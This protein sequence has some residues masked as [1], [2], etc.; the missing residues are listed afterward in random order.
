VALPIIFLLAPVAAALGAR[1]LLPPW[2]LG[3]TVLVT[4]L[5]AILSG[6]LALRT[7]R[8]VQP[9]ILLH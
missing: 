1:V 2:L 9:G 7:L 4:L 5:M 8:R 6:L 3:V